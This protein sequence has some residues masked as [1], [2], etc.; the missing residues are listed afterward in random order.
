MIVDTSLKCISNMPISET[1]KLAGGK[2]RVHFFPTKRMSTYLLYLGVG[3]Y[4]EVTGSIGKLKLRALATKGNKSRLKLPLSYAKRF[5]KYYEHYFDVKYSLPKIDLLAIPDFAA[6]AMENWGA[7]TFREQAMLADEKSAISFKQDVVET[8]SH[9]LAHMWFG[10]LVTMKWWDDIW[11]NEGFATFMSHKAMAA[12]MPEWDIP[13]QVLENGSYSINSALVT[14]QLRSTHA[15]NVSVNEPAEM[16]AMFDTGLAYSKGMAVLYMLEDY[17]GAETFRDGLHKYL[18]AYEYGN[19]TKHDLW[20]ALDDAAKSAKKSANAADIANY[21]V[22]EPGYPIVSVMRKGDEYVIT[23]KR[24]IVSDKGEEVPS[25]WPIPVHYLESNKTEGKFLMSKSSKRLHA[26]SQWIKLNYGQKG[27]YRVEYDSRL[28]ATIGNAIRKGELS[29]AD[30]WGVENDLFIRARAGRIAASAYLDFAE[31]YCF[32]C[33]YPANVSLLKHMNWLYTML[34]STKLADMARKPLVAYARKT[35]KRV[36]L[37][38]KSD[39]SSTDTMLR[40]LA[41]ST[42][43]LAEDRDTIEKAKAMFDGFVKGRKQLNKN[44][45]RA[46]YMTVAWNYPG[47]FNKFVSLYKKEKVIEDKLRFLATIGSFRETPLVRKALSFALSKDVRY[48]DVHYIP[49]YVSSNPYAQNLLWKWIAGN[50][51]TFLKRYPPSTHMVDE[52]VSFNSGISD[53]SL[54]EEVASFFRNKNNL[55]GDFA[56]EA[57]RTL[58]RID[59]NIKFMKANGV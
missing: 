1:E 35:L 45:R 46:V 53:A 15:I 39:E 32:D 18:K 28:T 7:I 41:F 34:Y 4:E 30:V 10:D 19:A 58:E 51:K 6:G 55:R 57:K 49:A 26:K 59:T 16:T 27:F 52:F 25:R 11:L 13:N 21:W 44:L 12:V 24:F 14:D 5:I 42:L 36:G 2:K 20:K 54:R 40:S 9:E 29:G 23:Q 31:R 48:Q 17:L 8:V 56:L 47:T 43:G 37:A 3:D 22:D 50:W 38:V 33:G